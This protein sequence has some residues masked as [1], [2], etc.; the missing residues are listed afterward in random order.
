MELAR[1]VALVQP[2]MPAL[3]RLHAPDYQLITPT[4]RSF[5]RERYLG[6][7]A[8]G[9]LRYLRWEPE[10]V[11]VRSCDNMAVVRYVATLQLGTPQEP[12]TAFRCWH[13]DS[14]E[15]RGGTWQAVWSQATKIAP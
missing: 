1:I 4:G 8:S 6:M 15:L 7:L 3:E 12:G 9:D 14:Y 13:T 5:T 10:V 11:A 2:D